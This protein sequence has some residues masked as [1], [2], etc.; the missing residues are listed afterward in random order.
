M[1]T[2]NPQQETTMKT[3]PQK[4]HQWLQRFVGEQVVEVRDSDSGRLKAR[5]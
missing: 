3:E 5:Q 1:E 2:S 4:E